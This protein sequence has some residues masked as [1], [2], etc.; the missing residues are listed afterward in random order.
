MTIKKIIMF[1]LIFC[2]NNFIFSNLIFSKYIS[3][4]ITTKIKK[5]EQVSNETQTSNINWKISLTIKNVGNDNAFDVYPNMIIKNKLY[6]SSEIDHHNLA[7]NNQNIWN[8]S[9][10]IS[11][12][13]S[14]SDLNSQINGIYPLEFY[15]NYKDSNGKDYS[16]TNINQINTG[17]YK[18]Q[19]F[20]MHLSTQNI[21]VNNNNEIKKTKIVVV[22]NSRDTEEYSFYAIAPTSIKLFIFSEFLPNVKRV[23]QLIEGQ[24]RTYYKFPLLP[25]EKI[26]IPIKIQ[27]L[28]NNPP[29]SL[30]VYYVLQKK[31]NL[32]E[33]FNYKVQRVE[34]V[35]KKV[36]KINLLAPLIVILIITSLSLAIFVIFSI[37]INK[38]NIN[39]N[40]GLS[41]KSNNKSD[42]K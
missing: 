24:E 8:F 29:S 34:I 31:T 37:Y 36:F 23:T 40:S 28:T 26:E 12:F 41:K 19:K 2:I 38:K 21:S 3:L 7:P 10:Y 27:N 1:A 22:N 20:N 25:N 30:F 11:D 35:A 39:K 14:T 18:Q 4:S 13:D 17:S 9:V 15:I 33:T 16:I 32:I 6:K 42:K 5:T